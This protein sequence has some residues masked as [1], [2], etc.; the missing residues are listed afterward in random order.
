MSSTLTE[1]PSDLPSPTVTDT[2]I[3]QLQGAAV[4]LCANG[5]PI[6]PVCYPTA[7]RL[8]IGITPPDPET[9]ADWWSEQPYGIACRTGELFDAIQV[10]IWLGER[11]LPAVEHYATV[12]E[13]R[14]S[15][16]AFWLFLVTKGARRITDLPRNCGLIVRGTGE[17]ILVPPTPTLGG[18]TR[19]VARQRELRLP[20]SLSLQWAAVR[21]VSMARRE[22]AARRPRGQRGLGQEMSAGR[23][24]GPDS[25]C[26]GIEGRRHERESV[27]V[28]ALAALMRHELRRA[29][30]NRTVALDVASGD[31][32]LFGAER[33]VELCVLGA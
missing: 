29:E 1:Q 24:T 13:V 5:W 27:F 11:L 25:G 4:R 32:H 10:P 19:W 33:P 20:H 3:A 26:H 16:E 21:A 14:R 23:G 12:I 22:R 18:G 28:R 15:L 30:A 7:D 31:V 8:V 9:A 6:L 17:W 2:T